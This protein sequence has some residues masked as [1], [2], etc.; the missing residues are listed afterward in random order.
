MGARTRLQKVG[1]GLFGWWHEPKSMEV[2]LHVSAGTVVRDAAV[3]QQHYVIEEVVHLGLGLQERYNNGGIGG[4]CPVSEGLHDCEG[5][6]RI[7]A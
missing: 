7:Q 1:N 2:P 3:G 6:S 5:G 4:V